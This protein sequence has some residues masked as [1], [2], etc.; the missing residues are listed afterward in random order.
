MTNLHYIMFGFFCF[1]QFLHNPTF[2]YNRNA[3]GLTAVPPDISVGSTLISLAMNNILTIPDDTFNNFPQLKELVLST[4]GLT[5]FP[6]VQ[7]VAS[8]IEILRLA[9]NV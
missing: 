6:N 4:N 2:G 3:D 8:T 1:L 5:H 9:K 7:P